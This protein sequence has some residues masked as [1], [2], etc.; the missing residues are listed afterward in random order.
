M[1]TDIKRSYKRNRQRNM[2]EEDKQKLQE[3]KKTILKQR[4]YCYITI[5]FICII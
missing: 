5:I 2:S 4:I 1:N 3:F